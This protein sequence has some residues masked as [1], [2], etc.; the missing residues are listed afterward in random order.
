MQNLRIYLQPLCNIPTVKKIK[1]FVMLRY[2]S[3]MNIT[4]IILQV[5]SHLVII[6]NKNKWLPFIY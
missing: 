5:E 6:D 1:V 4:Y 2:S 3:F